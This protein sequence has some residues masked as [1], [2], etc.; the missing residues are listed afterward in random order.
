MARTP[1]KYYFLSPSINFTLEK[2]SP[3]SNDYLGILVETFIASS[4]FR[5]KNTISKP[6]D[7]FTPTEK[8]M[9]DFI[10]TTFEGDRV[11]VE[12][13]IGEKGDSQVRKTMNRHNCQRG[14][15]V[16]S[17]MNLIERRMKSHSFL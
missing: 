7:I 14:F 10:V 5:L 17:P 2:H 6:C 3:T 13:S 4:F 9:V 15:V 1:K 16:S 8:G 12:V 11:A